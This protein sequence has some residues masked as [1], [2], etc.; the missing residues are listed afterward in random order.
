MRRVPGLGDD[1]GGG[2]PRLVR[3][4]VRAV[5]PGPVSTPAVPIGQVDAHGG[6]RTADRAGRAGPGTRRWPGT[7]RGG[8]AGRASRASGKSTLLLEAAAAGGRR[9]PGAGT[10]PAR[11][12][13]PRCG[14]GPTV[15]ARS[16]TN[17]YLAAETDLAAVL[18]H[19]ETVRPEPAR[20]RLGADDRGRRGGRRAGRRHPGPRG[21]RRADGDRQGARAGDDPGRPCHQGRVASPARARSSTWSTWCCTSRETGTPSCAWCAR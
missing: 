5:G 18:G 4:G 15:S 7:G 21:L 20:H 1:R 16:A 2:G 19:V 3:A 8:A 17:L 12:R 9:A 6:E 11:S 14:C 13:P 10:S